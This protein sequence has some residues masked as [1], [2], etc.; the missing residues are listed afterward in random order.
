MN[1]KFKVKKNIKISKENGK[2]ILENKTDKKGY[3]V[4][5]KPFKSSGENV[6]I[7]VDFKILSGE[8]CQIKL[9]NRKLKVVEQINESSVTYFDRINKLVFIGMVIS[10]NTVIQLNKINIDI[11]QRDE[12]IKRFFKG[13]ILLLTPGYPSE[14]DKYNCA[15]VHTRVKEYNK[16]GWKVDV[17]MVNET[18]IKKT[19]F[20]SFEGIKVVAT[21]YNDVRKILQERKYDKILIHFFDEKYAQILDASDLSS[22]N[23]FLYSHGADTMYWD[24]PQIA[25]KY[26]EK[27]TYIDETLRKKFKTKDQVIKKYNNMPN[28]K[29][30]FV[31]K[32]TQKNSEKLLGIKYKNA[33]VIPCLVDEKEFKYTKRN[34]ESRKKICM[35]RKFGDINTYS[36]D[37]NVRVILELSRRPFFKDLEFSIYGDGP[38]HDILLAPLRKF[39]NVH[40]YKRFLSHKEMAELYKTHGIS[41]FATRYD[42]QAV[43]SCE[44]AMAGSVVITSKGV[45]VSQFISE[46][47][48]TYCET[49][50]FKQYADKIEEL[51]YDE[52][53]FLDKSKQMHESVMKTCGYNQTIKKDIDLIENAKKVNIMNYKIKDLSAKPILTIA[54]PSYN[55]SKFIK[56]GIHSLMNQKYA[57]KLEILIINDGSKDDTAKIAKSLEKYGKMSNRNIIKLIDKPNGGHGSTINKGIELATGKYFK[58]MDGDDYFISSELEKFI[59]RLSKEDSDIILTNYIEDFSI[60]G[61][62]N[63]VRHYEFM[64][65]YI[66]YNLEDMSYYGYG[67]FPWGP[68]LSTST[69]KT[70]VLKTIPKI[71]ENCFYVDMEY[72]FFGY[73][74]S[75][76]VVY[77]PYDIYNYYLGRAGQSV[78][79]ESYIRN[80]SHHEKVC[81]RLVSEYE[82]VKNNISL[83]KRKYLINQIIIPMCK[84]Q[85]DITIEYFNTRKQFISYDKKLRTFENFYNMDKIAGNRV[86]MHRITNGFFIRFDSLIKKVFKILKRR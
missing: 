17:A 66:K 83:E 55:V 50:N 72:N 79:K 34:P 8:Y 73:I 29:W 40:I 37:I 22:T 65:P 68:L 43:A 20:Y 64:T 9:I 21:G 56:N 70:S 85:Y 32:W 77:Y 86:K 31:T 33:C 57:N 23:V 51:Y 24:W 30:V 53:L 16:L 35:I 10:P 4:F 69:Y 60:D 62:K 41:L 6:K 3:V 13:N 54:I 39:D 52:M 80:Y 26:F 63:V 42:S 81:I 74:N 7:N 82:K 11:E 25:A 75:K 14:G 45:G 48:G 84:S 78:S 61:F 59:E 71:D 27:E 18:L 44:A 46:K 2:I 49:E 5:L 28:V 15:F 1:L 58:L 12:N 76:T 36:I 67:F 19:Y 47:I 38:M